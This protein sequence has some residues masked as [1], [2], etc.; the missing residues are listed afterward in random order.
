MV[1]IENIKEVDLVILKIFVQSPEKTIEK[2]AEN[3]NKSNL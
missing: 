1:A 2:N 3:R